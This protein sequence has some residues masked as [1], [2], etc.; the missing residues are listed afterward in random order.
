M[1]GPIVSLTLTNFAE[2]IGQLNQLSQAVQGKQLMTAAKAGGLIP[3]QAAAEKAP[4]RT[5]T[6]ARSI[7][8]E[9]GDSSP[10]YAEVFVGPSDLPYAAI[11]EFGGVVSPKVAKLLAI[12]VDAEARTAGSPRGQDLVFVKTLGGQM[13]LMD[14]DGKIRYSLRRSVTIPAHPYL[15]PAFDENVERIEREVA[16]VL[17]EGIDAALANRGSYGVA[18][19]GG[20]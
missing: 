8:M 16:T 4:K 5:R 20:E 15:R 13:F 19:G 7:H 9:E 12:P 3:L 2:V 11:Q 10:T 17:R 18:A 14:K 6:L 1:S